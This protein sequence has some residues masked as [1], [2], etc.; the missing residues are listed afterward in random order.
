[1]D[2]A[3]V[4]NDGTLIKRPYDKVLDVYSEEAFTY[5]SAKMIH[6]GELPGLAH[7][8]EGVVL[9]I[10]EADSS[11]D[12]RSPRTSSDESLR[13][14]KYEDEPAE[15]MDLVMADRTGVVMVHLSG[16]AA[17]EGRNILEGERDGDKAVYLR[18][19]NFRTER[20]PENLRNGK[21]LTP[22]P[23]LISKKD[24]FVSS[25]DKDRSVSSSR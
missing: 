17:T 23:T 14:R 12:N 19:E 21:V 16:S 2:V 13:K 4:E 7:I 1:M 10:L 24:R 20:L 5:T 6:C 3:T 11:I 18:I 15:T 22:M 9:N 25:F 8:F